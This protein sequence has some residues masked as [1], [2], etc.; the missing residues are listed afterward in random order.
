MADKRPR[1]RPS[2]SLVRERL[3]DMVFCAGR[4]TAY[5]AHKHYIAIFPSCTRRNVYY[6]LRKGVSKG[7][8]SFEEVEEAGDFS[9]GSKTRKVYYELKRKQGVRAVDARVADYFAALKKKG[10]V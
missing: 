3:R 10:D 8:F 5:T 9:W 1:G 4:M 2:Y 7:D 6:Q